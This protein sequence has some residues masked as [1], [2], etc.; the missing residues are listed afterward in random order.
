MTQLALPGTVS[1]TE[2][3][4]KI[5][6]RLYSNSEASRAE[7][8][9][10]NLSLALLAHFQLH[11]SPSGRAALAAFSGGSISEKD[12][13]K[14]VREQNT[15]LLEE[16]E[17]FTIGTSQLRS[18]FADL[19]E[20]DTDASAHVFG[21]AFQALMGPRLRG[22]KGQFFTPRS[23]IRCMVEIADPG[24]DSLVIDPACG[25]GGFLTESLI[26]SS[27]TNGGACK[28]LGQDKDRDLVRLTQATV[29]MGHAESSAQVR[30]GNSLDLSFWEEGS[31]DFVLTNP[32]FGAKIGI[33]DP[34]I[35]R[36]YDFGHSAPFGGVPSTSSINL[37]TSQDPQVLFIELSVRLLK[38]SG[39]MA[40]ILPEGIFGNKQTSYIWEWLEARGSV[41]GLLDCPRTTFQPGTDT[42][43]NVLFFRKGLKQARTIRIGVATHCGHDRRGRLTA[44]SG[45]P[46]T[47]DFA[48]LSVAY[49]SGRSRLWTKAVQPKDK[50]FVPRYLG[51]QSRIKELDFGLA[52]DCKRVS[53]SEL[54]DGGQL[55]LSK[56]H[57][58]GSE[59]YGTGDVPF[60]RTSDISNFE[61]RSDRTN[62]VA[63]EI[64]EKYAEQQK[65]QVGDV[66]LVVDGR[67]R[68]GAAAILSA[69][70]SRIVV[71]SHLRILQSLDHSLLN[72][73]SLL[74]ALTLPGVKEQMRD[75]VFIQSTLGTV[76]PRLK[77]LVIPLITETS[78]AYASQSKFQSLLEQRDRLLAQLHEVATSDVEL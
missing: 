14:I 53:I 22:D 15:E 31:A 6:Y 69:G 5:Y 9:M 52:N 51:L 66:L 38:P 65:L 8:I 11:S 1:A 68:I 32:P 77:E 13:L 2:I 54:V 33:N 21:D 30:V 64:Y 42:K 75:L 3:F 47:N 70:N 7:T 4:R 46:I 20:I 26:Y 19:Q 60:V 17:R 58:V 41:E 34:T 16:D 57:E 12:L 24:P 10:A 74:Y 78:S 28:V 45:Q 39:L 67:Y 43:T 49:S 36:Q 59:A 56:G 44:T 73:Y 71:Q 76:S 48:K 61:I 29:R 35:L 50:Y 25:T 40:I 23:L 62:G 63:D 72:P 37:H 27:E 55:R 18:V